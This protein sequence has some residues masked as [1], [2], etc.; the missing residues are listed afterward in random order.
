MRS[1]LV[2]AIV[3]LS[4][5]PTFA[6][7]RASTRLTLETA[8]DSADTAAL[9]AAADSMRTVPQ[10]V[11]RTFQRS[12]FK[13]TLDPEWRGRE[14]ID[15]T[16]APSYSV[17]SFTESQPGEPMDGARL[18]VERVTNLNPVEQ[19]RWRLGQGNYGYFDTQ[20]VALYDVDIPNSRAIEVAGRGIHGVLVFF[21]RGQTFYTLLAT[22]TDAA[23]AADKREVE[24]MIYAVDFL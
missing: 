11:V 21:R 8:R 5:A 7:S 24:D 1:I 10:P 15:E 14:F 12:G 13:V 9:I 4:V 3:V 20:P 17:Y 2:A 18:R 23:W 16:R 19:E 6:Q 22:G